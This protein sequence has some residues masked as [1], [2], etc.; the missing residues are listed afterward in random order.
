[1]ELKK[2]HSGLV[3]KTFKQNITYK[4]SLIARMLRIVRS[5]MSVEFMMPNEVVL[6]ELDPSKPMYYDRK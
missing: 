4:G 2:T 6:I 5:L 1:M 3:C